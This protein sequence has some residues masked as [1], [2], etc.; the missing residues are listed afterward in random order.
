VS[1][2]LD[3]LKKSDQER[4]RGD[5]PDLQ[6]VHI[7]ISVEQRLPWALY[8][9]ISLLILVLV[10]VT[11]MMISS[12]K[13]SSLVQSVDMPEQIE[14]IEPVDID[15]HIADKIP[16]AKSHKVI[17]PKIESKAQSAILAKQPDAPPAKPA[18]A[19]SQQT[20]T[21]VVSAAD[22]IPDLIEIPYLHELPEYQQQSIPEMSFAGH[23]YSSKPTSRSVI[24][25]GYAMSEGDTIVQGI[26]IEQITPVGVVFSLHNEFFRMDVLQD[27][28]F[29]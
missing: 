23:V 5:V 18:L 16:P 29:D 17:P 2:I 27:W 9:F 4:K 11:G 7:P 25:N 15:N 3:A 14:Q 21:A 28:S 6:T 8:G 22:S 13:T 24:I 10:F 26:N 12:N 1:Y 20:P 19:E